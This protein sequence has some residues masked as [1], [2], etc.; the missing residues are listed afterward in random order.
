MFYTI[1]SDDTK[2]LL[3]P[4][5]ISKFKNSALYKIIFI[6]NYTHNYL[7]FD[8]EHTVLVDI[9]SESLKIII[10]YMRNYITDL[11][12][13]NNPIL[14]EKVYKDANILELT[15][16]ADN[17][18][19]MLPVTTHNATT[20][21]I[22][23]YISTLIMT[24]NTLNKKFYIFGHH[25]DNALNNCTEEIN[26]FLQS[27]DGKDI[28]ASIINKY[29]RKTCI[30]NEFILMSFIILTIC[31]HYTQP[32]HYNEDDKNEFSSD[33]QSGNGS[34]YSNDT[35]HLSYQTDENMSNNVI[36]DDE[37][38]IED[39]FNEYTTNPNPNPQLY[40]LNMKLDKT[41]DIFNIIS[42]SDKIHDTI[43][44]YKSYA[45]TSSDHLPL[46]DTSD[47]STDHLPLVDTSDVSSSD[48]NV[49][50]DVL[51]SDVLSSD[52][53]SSDNNITSK[54]YVKIL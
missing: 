23:Q 3:S 25:S 39:V 40:Q 13:I 14:I 8:E 49:S 12:D 42:T 18:H 21:I 5:T 32:V 15:E 47:V 36:E 1:I 16:F 26:Q 31:K 46:V 4:T 11:S 37:Q 51:S 38:F 52:V 6:P 35:D 53:L 44:Q 19:D 17:L 30:P 2:F 10:D 43:Q 9:C 22:N 34:N 27:S 24:L 54:N 7:H 48:N 29:N 20:D 33:T 28:M 41:N 50:S 45:N